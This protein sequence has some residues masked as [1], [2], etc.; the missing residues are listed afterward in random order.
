MSAL[1]LDDRNNPSTVLYYAPRRPR[2]VDVPAETTIRPVLERLRR[3]GEGAVPYVESPPKAPHPDEIVLTLEPDTHRKVFAVAGHF[4]AA[5][6]ICAGIG[7]FAIWLHASGHRAPP[8]TLASQAMPQKSQA[9]LTADISNAVAAATNRGTQNE[10]IGSASPDMPPMPQATNAAVPALS[11]PQAPL[12]MTSAGWMPAAAAQEGDARVAV[13]E[14]QDAE[15]K[16]VEPKA[17]EHEQRDESRA[18]HAHRHHVWHSRHHHAVRAAAASAPQPAEQT[19]AVANAS[20][21]VPS[22]NDHSLNA[23]LRRL[24]S[25]PAQKQDTMQ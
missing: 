7:A 4:A 24:F 21:G 12:D 18:A 8:A 17:V 9:R 6:A 2:D 11:W 14:P 13:A 20:A 5:A 25:S 1:G 16:P 19:Q 22:P 15:V 23:A 3:N 10:T